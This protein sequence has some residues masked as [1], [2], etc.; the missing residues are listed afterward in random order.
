MTSF[1]LTG[2]VRDLIEERG[3]EWKIDVIK[4]IFNERDAKNILAMPVMDEMGEDKLC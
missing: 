2:M 3:S 1:V 4:E